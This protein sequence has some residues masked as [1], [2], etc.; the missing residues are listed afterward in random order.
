MH[1]EQ[2]ASAIKVA[3]VVASATRWVGALAASEGLYVPLE[4]QG[5]WRVLSFVMA[6]AMA[7][8]E[9][10]AFSYALRAWRYMRPDS[11]QARR[12]MGLI[13]L[14]A[15]TFVAVMTPSIVAY[16]QHTE[17]DQVLFGVGLWLWGVA[18]TLSTVVVLGMVGYAQGRMTAPNTKADTTRYD[19]SDVSKSYQCVDC[20]ES[21][22][23][24][25]AY[26]IHRRWA[27]R[28]SKNGQQAEV[29]DQPR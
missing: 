29:A 11:P 24:S 9:A 19:V 1:S 26:A 3:A 2:Q 14:A 22:E 5:W 18:V 10:L 6:G 17:I 7:V 28:Q 12:M 13:V 25:Q 21:F 16:V 8:V 20:G 4:W 15:V 23:A 27:H